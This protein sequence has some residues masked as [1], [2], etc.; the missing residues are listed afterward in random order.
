MK[1]RWIEILIA[2]AMFLC[3]LWWSLK[4][5]DEPARLIARWIVTF[6][7]V[8]GMFKIAVP[9]LFTSQAGAIAGVLIIAACGVIIGITWA[10]NWTEIA[11]SPLTNAFDGGNEPVE[12]KPVYS[13]AET[14][15]KRGNYREAMAE[16]DRQLEIFPNDFAGLLL[17]AEIHARDLN[18]L[19]EA[20]KVVDR[21]CEAHEK[22]PS[23]VAASLMAM[24]DWYLQRGQVPEAQENLRRIILLC[25]D[26][27]FSQLAAQRLGHME[28]AQQTY[29]ARSRT[30]VMAE[31]YQKD[32]GLQDVVAAPVETSA[33]RTASEYVAHLQLHPLDVEV[34][35][36]LAV[37][38]AEQYQRMDLATLEFEHLIAQPNQTARQVA[39]HLNM[40][41]DWQV[42]LGYGNE[43]R[44][45]LG[46]IVQMFPGT[47]LGDSAQ[48]RLA[49]LGTELR[50]QQKSQ[51]SV[52]L[53][54][55]KKDLGLNRNH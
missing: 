36:R 55:Y 26:S 16:I 4:K 15:R 27:S 32:V 23:H 35:Q 53:G 34:R 17:L 47:A 51:A 37:L 43:A 28:Q 10:S 18:D 48:T 38:Y 44:A 31:N 42:K 11:L 25:P 30:I 12:E 46:R 52:K 45:T 33:A 3:M 50:G 2:A 54:S 49:N 41:A 7:M 19:G 21:I 8:G 9:M 39:Q 22:T 29:D 20:Q 14:K 6:L 40:L 1:F 5:S 13:G 24:A